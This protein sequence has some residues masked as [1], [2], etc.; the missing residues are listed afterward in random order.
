[1]DEDRLSGVGLGVFVGSFD[2]FA[3]LEAGAGPDERDEVR[4]GCQNLG[5][6]R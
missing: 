3:G 6:G 2:E 4:V 1:V 5:L